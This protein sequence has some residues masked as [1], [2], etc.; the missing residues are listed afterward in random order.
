MFFETG[1]DWEEEYKATITFEFGARHK[2]VGFW[3]DASGFLSYQDI[4]LQDS[5]YYQQFSYDI[6]ST[7]NPETYQNLAM[8]VHPVGAKMF[9]TYILG[10]DLDLSESY[11]I[12]VTFPFVSL[13]FFDVARI[14]DE[15]AKYLHKPISDALVGV[16]D[17]E[18]Y[19]LIKN[20]IDETFAT[21]ICN[22]IFVRKSLKDVAFTNETSF[23]LLSKPLFDDVLTSERIDF[24]NSKK[25][26]ETVFI[27][28]YSAFDVAK[29]LEDST[30]HTD[31]V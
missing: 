2:E 18:F 13:S 28:E 22:E 9:T 29:P 16:K 1:E 7:A 31:A 23:I 3:A 19:N 21:D 6:V 30:N 15:G 10:T 11:D 27:N 12:D 8:M 5:Y 17:K 14:A 25:I 26:D 20:L 24:A 4:R